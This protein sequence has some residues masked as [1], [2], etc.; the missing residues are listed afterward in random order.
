MDKRRSA[1]KIS[2]HLHHQAVSGENKIKL[3]GKVKQSC[4]WGI[5]CLC[6]KLDV[7]SKIGN[8]H[9]TRRIVFIC[10]PMAYKEHRSGISLPRQAAHVHQGKQSVE[11]CAAQGVLGPFLVRERFVML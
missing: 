4:Q 1:C 9:S 11:E 8:P 3:F 5:K 6:Q 10:L 7:L 2:G